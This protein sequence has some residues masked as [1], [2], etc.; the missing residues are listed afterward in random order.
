M[1]RKVMMAMK[2][3]AQNVC[4]IHLWRVAGRRVAEIHHPRISAARAESFTQRTRP[5]FR[6]NHDGDCRVS[7]PA[8]TSTSFTSTSPWGAPR[9]SLGS[10]AGE[11][12]LFSGRSSFV[13]LAAMSKDISNVYSV[14]PIAENRGRD[15]LRSWTVVVKNRESPNDKV[16]RRRCSIRAYAACF[17]YHVEWK[18]GPV[19]VEFYR[20]YQELTSNQPPIRLP[21]PAA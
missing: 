14:L 6:A 9:F 16:E 4:T 8:I 15:C 19:S 10:E 2:D 13:S 17:I 20:K 12:D 5:R 21:H 3:Q 7:W 1:N 18:F 11:V